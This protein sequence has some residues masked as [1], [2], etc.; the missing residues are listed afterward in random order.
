MYQILTLALLSFI[1]TSS[2]IRTLP[3][4]RVY[5]EFDNATVVKDNKNYRL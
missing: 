5:A 3:I 2:Y 1:V 4:R